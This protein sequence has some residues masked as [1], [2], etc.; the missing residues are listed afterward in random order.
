MLT[1]RDGPSCAASSLFHA[2]RFFKVGGS[3]H[4]SRLVR[5]DAETVQ[6]PLCD[7]DKRVVHGRVLSPRLRSWR[8][9]DDEVE[10]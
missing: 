4:N 5:G 2:P 3:C 10:I 6:A 9:G 8:V 1:E 7:R